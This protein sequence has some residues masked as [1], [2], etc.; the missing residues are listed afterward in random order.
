[1]SSTV[2]YLKTANSKSEGGDSAGIPAET[3][4]PGLASMRTRVWT[5]NTME[6]SGRRGRCVCPVHR[7]HKQGILGGTRWPARLTRISELWTQ[8]EILTQ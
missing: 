1:M 3:G 8:G 2:A 7:K 6:K 5:P 4:V